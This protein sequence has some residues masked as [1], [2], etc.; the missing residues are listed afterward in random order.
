ME[1]GERLYLLSQRV[2]RTSWSGNCF[3]NATV[4]EEDSTG[5]EQVIVEETEGTAEGN[6]AGELTD[7]EACRLF[8]SKGTEALGGMEV[9]DYQ[10]VLDAQLTFLDAIKEAGENAADPDFRAVAGRRTKLA[11]RVRSLTD[12]FTLSQTPPLS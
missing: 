8:V 7:N 9:S 2:R 5:V 10:T 3:G 1:S 12:E 11:L 6:T 4:E